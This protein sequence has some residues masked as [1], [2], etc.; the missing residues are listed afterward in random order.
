MKEIA[1]VSRFVSFYTIVCQSS[2]NKESLIDS[3]KCGH[4]NQFAPEDIVGTQECT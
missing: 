2:Q 1:G 3:R 4:A